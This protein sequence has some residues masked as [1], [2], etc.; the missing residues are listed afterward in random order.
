MNW[1]GTPLA[2]HEIIVNLI[3]NTKTKAGLTIEANINKNAYHTGVKISDEVF[4]SVNII[5]ED[6]H[7]EWNYIINPTPA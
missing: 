1:S 5:R 3:A 6:F 2:S 7:G 4:N